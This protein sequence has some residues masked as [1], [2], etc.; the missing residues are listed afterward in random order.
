MVLCFLIAEFGDIP[1][2][3]LPYKWVLNRLQKHNLIILGQHILQEPAGGFILDHQN[4]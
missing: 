3:I 4:S 2:K 1:T